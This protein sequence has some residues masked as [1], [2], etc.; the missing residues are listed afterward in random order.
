MRAETTIDLVIKDSNGEHPI[1]VDKFKGLHPNVA[2][3]IIN[4]KY[5]TKS[6]KN[7]N[8]KIRKILKNEK[9]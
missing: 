9:R 4:K 2:L 6:L 3:N 8:K 1:I 7:E 5:R